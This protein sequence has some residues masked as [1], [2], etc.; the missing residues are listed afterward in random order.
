M[1]SKD[2]NTPNTVNIQ[3][4]LASIMEVLSKT[5]V[6]EITKVFDDGFLVL[7]LE[8]CRKDA[9]IEALYKKLSA[10]EGDILS[11]RRTSGSEARSSCDEDCREKHVE[12]NSNIREPE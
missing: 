5:A 2:T 8:M 10:L 3:S 4:R 1:L 6:A 9:K 11:T 7:R 12:G